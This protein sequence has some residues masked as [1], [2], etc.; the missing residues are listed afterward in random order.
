[1]L[2]KVEVS[3]HDD[4]YR[5]LESSKFCFSCG[6]KVIS[7]PHQNIDSNP[8]M[9]PADVKYIRFRHPKL[10][11]HSEINGQVEGINSKKAFQ[12]TEDENP[13]V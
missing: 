11:L 12:I 6:E 7:C 13:M 1:M 9:V 8:M 5:I 2:T 3:K 4:N 10:Q